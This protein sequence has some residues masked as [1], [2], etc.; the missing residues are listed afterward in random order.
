[1]ASADGV[2]F[3]D[4]TVRRG[5]NETAA[6]YAVFVQNPSFDPETLQWLFLDAESN[7]WNDV[8]GPHDPWLL[9]GVPHD[10]D[11]NYNPPAD[12]VNDGVDYW[13]WEP[14]VVEW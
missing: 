1:M 9:E 4:L 12:R 11:Y 10:G 2:S 8:N 3:A 7:W 5:H 14:D 6:A 13:P